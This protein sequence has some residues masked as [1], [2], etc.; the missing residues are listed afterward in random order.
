[1]SSLEVAVPNVELW[2][3]AATPTLYWIICPFSPTKLCPK[4]P[5]VT[6]KVFLSSSP[7]YPAPVVQVVVTPKH[8]ANTKSLEFEVVSPP[9]VATPFEA[10]VVLYCGVPS[11]AIVPLY[12][13]SAHSNA[14]NATA[15]LTVKVTVVEALTAEGT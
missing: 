5:L 4:V 1:M 12:E 8:A 11:K 13:Y 10:G 15:L 14:R 2:A 7:V 3:P 9:I 6:S